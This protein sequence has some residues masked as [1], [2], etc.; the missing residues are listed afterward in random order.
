MRIPCSIQISFGKSLVT[1]KSY[2]VDLLLQTYTNNFLVHF[3]PTGIIFPLCFKM[4]KWK[5]SYLMG[6]KNS[7]CSDIIFLS[8]MSTY[9]T[10]LYYIYID[11]ILSTFSPSRIMGYDYIYTYMEKVIYWLVWAGHYPSSFFLV[12]FSDL[13]FKYSPLSH[14][15]M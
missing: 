13:L 7:M 3:F 1:L 8:E 15:S 5:A 4:S 10:F 9:I 6:K 14:Q 2:M 11:S 12:I